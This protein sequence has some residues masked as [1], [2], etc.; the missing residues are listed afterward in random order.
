MLHKQ[1]LGQ[2]FADY[3]G[4]K[5]SSPLEQTDSN[6][7]GCLQAALDAVVDCGGQGGFDP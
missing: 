6:A 1:V 5:A 4:K 2:I 3:E 7:F